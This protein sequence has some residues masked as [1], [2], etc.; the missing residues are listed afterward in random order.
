MYEQI[1]KDI[2]LTNSEISVY[3]ALLEIGSSTT[4]PIVKKANIAHGKAYLVLDKLV[5]KGLVTYIIRNGRKH[6]QAKDPERLLDYLKEKENQLQKILPRLKKQYEEEKYTPIAEV[7]EGEK[8]WKS[9]YEWSLKESKPGETI[10]VLGVPRKALDR[11][12]EYIHDWNKRRIK[13]G[14]KMEIIYNQDCREEGR[15]RKKLPLTKVKFMESAFETPAWIYIFQDYVVNINVHGT[16]ICFLI[17][18]KE[19]AESY[20]KYFEIMWKHAIN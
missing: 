8:G 13:M 10:L 7:Y 5:M 18:S 6:Y 1:L 17:K 3:F 14:I 15:K 19:S 12:L 16:P 2:G 9:L 4:G 11:Y 20:K